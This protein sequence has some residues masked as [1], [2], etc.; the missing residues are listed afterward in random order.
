MLADA[1]AHIA[2]VAIAALSL[3]D[4]AALQSPDTPALPAETVFSVTVWVCCCFFSAA[5]VHPAGGCLRL[6]AAPG[7]G[8]VLAALAQLLSALLPLLSN[9]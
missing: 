5:A 7:Y 1:A 8:V 3:L 4:T 2:A 9:G 6:L